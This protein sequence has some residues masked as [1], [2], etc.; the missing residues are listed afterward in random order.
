MNILEWRQA[1]LS[2]TDVLDL[3]RGRTEL[4]PLFYT[5]SLRRLLAGS[6]NS[7]REDPVH[8]RRRLNNSGLCILL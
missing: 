5:S 6:Y 3:E 8:H 7:H 2:S 4:S 1:A